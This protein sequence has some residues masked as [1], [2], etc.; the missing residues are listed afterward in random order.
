MKR[1]NL[2]AAASTLAIATIATQANPGSAQTKTTKAVGQ[3]VQLDQD[4]TG[5]YV[6]PI[7][8]RRLTPQSF[9]AVIVIM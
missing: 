8:H 2:F 5:Y 1:R 9:P 7:G 6:T 4:L 3:T